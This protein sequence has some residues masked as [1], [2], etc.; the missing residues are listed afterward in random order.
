M[1]IDN[2]LKQ[3]TIDIDNQKLQETIL[4]K[5]SKTTSFDFKIKS[6]IQT[7]PTQVSSFLKND[8]IDKLNRL[9]DSVTAMRVYNFLLSNNLMDTFL[10]S[11][12]YLLNYKNYNVMTYNDI[13]NYILSY[14]SS[15]KGMLDFLKEDL[16][17]KL[18]SKTDISQLKQLN[19]ITTNANMKNKIKIASQK[20]PTQEKINKVQN[21]DILQQMINDAEFLPDKAQLDKILSRTR[22]TKSEMKEAELMGFED[23]RSLE[24]KQTKLERKIK[25]QAE[26]SKNIESQFPLEY[27]EKVTT[28]SSNKTDELERF[29]NSVYNNDLSSN[30]SLTELENLYS[31]L[32]KVNEGV[33]KEGY[34][35]V[36]DESFIR[37][38]LEEAIDAAKTKEKQYQQQIFSKNK[39]DD[40]EYD[41]DLKQNYID[42]Y[43]IGVNNEIQIDNKEIDIMEELNKKSQIEKQEES[44]QNLSQETNITEDELLQDFANMSQEFENIMTPT[45]S[46]EEFEPD[47]L[48]EIDDPDYNIKMFNLTEKLKREEKEEEDIN[49]KI[50]WRKTYKL[51]HDKIDWGLENNVRI[52]V[53]DN[54]KKIVEIKNPKT[55]DYIKYGGPSHK[56][57]AKPKKGETTATM[58]PI[59]WDNFIKS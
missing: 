7:N 15:S 8:I 18:K 52:V 10:K 17:E 4:N 46:Q 9:V 23:I 14:Q 19:K 57:L 3:L 49:T 30:F 16:K 53:D 58:S 54:N 13:I 51:S 38:E 47:T 56:A 50:L 36:N 12:E 24:N 25:K 39:F 42:K 33:D 5:S 21:I 27:S 32:D 44:S 35:L 28:K 11:Y 34:P 37:Y 40:P 48:P 6:M 31:Q 59:I 55:G 45:K 20:I 2:Y 43:N 22:R 26:E 29:M 41:E 1:N